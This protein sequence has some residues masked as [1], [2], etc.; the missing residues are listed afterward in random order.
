MRLL[1]AIVLL[2]SFASAQSMLTMDQD[3]FGEGTLP[4]NRNYP[5]TLDMN[6]DFFRSRE[7]TLSKAKAGEYGCTQV[8]AATPQGEAARV[9]RVGKNFCQDT[10]SVRWVPYSVANST[11]G[12]FT[13][14][15]KGYY[16]ICCVKKEGRRARRI[17]PR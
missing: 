3:F 10:P 11:N 8:S 16:L 7:G 9:G 15:V 1:L 4:S 13:S 12:T 17:G 5:T 6:P 2:S 14:T